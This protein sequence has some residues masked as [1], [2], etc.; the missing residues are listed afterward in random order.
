VRK[1]L[2]TDIEALQTFFGKPK[3]VVERLNRGDT[4]FLLV[5]DG[6]IYAA[7]WLASGAKDYKED[8]QRLHCVFRFPAGVCWLYDGRG[9]GKSLGPWGMLMGSLPQYFNELGIF[10][11]YLAVD[12]GNVRSLANHKTLGYQ[13]AGRICHIRI[14]RFSRCLFRPSG[15]NWQSTPGRV[16]FLELSEA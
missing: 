1:A 4:C 11:V 3:K 12:Y 9:D 15:L 5:S 7:E 13:M 8:W 10:H 14:G 6:N 16:G 2:S